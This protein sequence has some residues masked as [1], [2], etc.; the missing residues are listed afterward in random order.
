VH[1]D[2]QALVLGHNR[3]PRHRYAMPVAT[4]KAAG[5]NPLCGDSLELFLRIENDVI[6]EASFTAQAGALTLTSAS[7]L[8]LLVEN[9]DT[10][11]ADNLATRV[12]QTFSLEGVTQ[13]TDTMDFGDLALLLGVRRYPNRL[14]TI[15]LPWAALRAALCGKQTSTTE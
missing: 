4:H 11:A 6:L 12:I 8:T 1:A 10:Q 2:A 13:E 5:D 3:S 14:K 7:L 9:L 15:T